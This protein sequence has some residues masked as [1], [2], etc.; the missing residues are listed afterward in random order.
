M[1]A[2]AGGTPVTSATEPSAAGVVPVRGR[3][4]LGVASGVTGAVIGSAGAAGS[5][6]A[7]GTGSAGGTGAGPLNR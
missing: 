6:A 2:A 5:G 7:D 4:V 3:A 1:V